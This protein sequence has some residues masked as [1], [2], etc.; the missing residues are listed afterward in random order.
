METHVKVLGAINIVLGGLGILAGFLGLAVLTGI[1]GA[2]GMAGRGEPGAWIAVPL[3]SV[4][5]TLVFFLLALISLPCVI[6]GAGLLKFRPWARI[7]V[8]LLSVLN[9]MNF[10]V[11]TVVGVYGLWVLLSKDTERLFQAGEAQTGSPAPLP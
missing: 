9:L 10:P 1:A 7:L 6:G 4:L 5:G 11:G 2:A 3:F 8:I